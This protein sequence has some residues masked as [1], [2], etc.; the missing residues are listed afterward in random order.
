MKS[1][2]KRRKNN[3]WRGIYIDI[4]RNGPKENNLKAVKELIDNGYAKGTVHEMSDGS[5]V[6]QG[7]K[8]IT[9]EGKPFLERLETEEYR[10]SFRYRAIL[11]LSGILTWIA[12]M[13]SSVVLEI[14][15][16]T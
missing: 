15:K 14:Y 11:I 12:G 1:I 5:F 2:L 6:I 7:W 9:L 10:S 8:G 16:C 13:A 3:N 4:L